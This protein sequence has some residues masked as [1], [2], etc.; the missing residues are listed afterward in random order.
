MKI[1]VLLEEFFFF[2]TKENDKEA[3]V[4]L[5]LFLFLV[6]STPFNL[7]PRLLFGKKSLQILRETPKVCTEHIGIFKL[8]YS[9]RLFLF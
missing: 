9:Y 8:D 5:K 3:R 4:F 1:L 6:P 7:K 2:S